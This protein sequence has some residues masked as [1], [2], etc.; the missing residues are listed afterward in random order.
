MHEKGFS[1]RTHHVA[2]VSEDFSLGQMLMPSPESM[3]YT[4]DLVR[5]YDYD[6]FLTSL[7]APEGMRDRL[8]TL[9][10]FNTEIARIRE[11]VSEP[12]IG[13][14]RLQWWR[15]VLTAVAQG[16]RP[17]KGHPVA[18]PLAD[19]IIDTNLSFSHFE[20]LL[21]AREMDVAEESVESFTD[22]I[23]YCSNTSS[24]LSLLALEC[25]EVTDET[26]FKAAQ[27]LGVA[28]ALTGIARSVRHYALAGKAVLPASM[29]EEANLTLH[30]LQS[31]DASR[32]TAPAI[33]KL[34]NAA[35]DYL[36]QTRRVK[37]SVDLRAMPV[38][39][40][41]VLAEQYLSQ[42]ERCD[43]DLFHPRLKAMRP[44]VP[45]LWWNAWRKDF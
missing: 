1:Q 12:L 3:S 22:L 4:S 31:P 37:K 17:Q 18:E 33:S 43:F 25:L 36:Q 11:T 21:T 35:R 5:Q 29:M 14:M 45:R 34:V 9:Y 13:Q 10:A 15:D 2:S 38:L 19:L 24:T 16:E 44:S 26:T 6:R 32:K 27:S 42:I 23:D 20:A 28:W 30:D 7:F 8:H 40:H 41:S 39:L